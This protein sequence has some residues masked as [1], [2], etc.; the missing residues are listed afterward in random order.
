MEGETGLGKL[1]KGLCLLLPKQNRFSFYQQGGRDGWWV[2]SP[3]SPIPRP[4]LLLSQPSIKDRGELRT[5]LRCSQRQSGGATHHSRCPDVQDKGA[6][7]PAQY[8]L[9]LCQAACSCFPVSPG[10]KAVFFPR[11]KA[12]TILFPSNIG[13]ARACLWPFLLGS[14]CQL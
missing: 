8:H 3:S 1:L 2:I 12:A 4:R 13:R 7:A 10:V 14:P 6:R 11:G 9:A 5:W